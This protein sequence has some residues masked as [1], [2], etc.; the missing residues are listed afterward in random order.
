MNPIETWKTNVKPSTFY[1]YMLYFKKF[2]AFTSMTAE[3]LIKLDT[4]E[5]TQLAK[6]FRNKYANE[7]AAPH[8]ANTA[9]TAVR[10]FFVWNDKPLG[11]TPRSFKGYTSYESDIIYTP[12]DMWKMVNSITGQHPKRDRAIIATLYQGAQRIKVLT[13][14]K[15]RHLLHAPRIDLDYRYI[16]AL[17]QLLSN[18]PVV[19]NV[20][21]FLP[22]IKGN[23]V[24]KEPI[25]YRFALSDDACYY[26]KEMIL[27]RVQ[28]GEPING[29]T[30][31]FRS[32]SANGESHPTKVASS[33]RGFPLRALAMTHIFERAAENAGIQSYTTTRKG[34]KKAAY[35]PHG[36]R[37]SW[38]HQMR[39]AGINDADFLNFVQGHKL[40]Y[41]GAY[42]KFTEAMLRNY[43]TQA[44]NELNFIPRKTEKTDMLK[45]EIQ[46]RLQGIP[47]EQREAFLKNALRNVAE[48]I[49]NYIMEDDDIQ[50]C[51]REEKNNDNGWVV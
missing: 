20:P 9:Y 49:R 26:I 44:R 5:A 50:K 23:N 6:A 15:F 47:P 38:K 17:D 51:L 43:Y 4:K 42:D 25:K 40:A 32:Y 41:G 24:L 30:W 29:D 48:P 7:G 39:A 35:H 27:Q 34:R 12:E 45:A 10:S 8:T 1:I 33:K 22:D 16:E 13:G 21:A 37:R 36:C 18:P 2:M 28:A 31:L 19:I 3:E 46:A 11:R 14:F